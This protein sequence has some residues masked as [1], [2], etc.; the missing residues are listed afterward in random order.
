MLEPIVAPAPKMAK[1]VT[2]VSM[3]QSPSCWKELCGREQTRIAHLLAKFLAVLFELGRPS[4]GCRTTLANF[5][6]E[7]S[8]GGGRLRR[9]DWRTWFLVEHTDITPREDTFQVCAFISATPPY[10][11]LVPKVDCFRCGHDTRTVV[12][13]V[14]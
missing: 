10:V 14:L 9:K 7:V 3:I 5:E 12:V 11:M 13:H 6:W 8:I 1:R 4:A 2:Q